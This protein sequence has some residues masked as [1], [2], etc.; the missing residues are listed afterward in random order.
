MSNI[1]PEEARALR[2]AAGGE[3]TRTAPA[4]VES[5]D[6]SVPRRLSARQLK[7]LGKLATTA[8]QEIGNGIAPLLRSFHKLSMAGVSEVNTTT[9][10]D[11]LEPPF[12]VLCFECEGQPGWLVWEPTAALAAIEAILSSAPEEASAAR[13]LSSSEC[14]VLERLLTH[15]A[16]P[17][18]RALGFELSKSYVAQEPEA[19][20]SLDDA[21]PDADPQRLLIH[22]AFDGP[23]EPSD[24]CLYLPGVSPEHDEAG[25]RRGDALPA[26]L[27]PVPLKVA[28]HLASIDVPLT[29]LLELE[30]GDVI[31]LG[32]RTGTPVDIYIEDRACAKGRMGSHLGRLAV[33]I[34]KLSPSSDEL[35]QPAP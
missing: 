15:V 8:L 25:R 24:L 16:E 27:E 32:V 21:G 14:R 20:A 29:D 34:E 10:V 28:A 1:E 9:L 5:R 11:E 2:E 13:L 30:V 33:Q 3:P 26:H 7:R 22:L 18:A 35:D 31:P 17:I 6:F 19:L 4:Q 12:V 23:G